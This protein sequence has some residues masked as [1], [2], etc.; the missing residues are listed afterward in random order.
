L[1]RVYVSV[2]KLQIGEVL[3]TLSVCLP[4]ASLAP[5]R[6]LAEAPSW[7]DFVQADPRW[8]PALTR[9]VQGLQVSLAARC[10]PLQTSLGRVMALRAGDFIELGVH[11][12]TVA[13]P[14]GLPLFEGRLKTQSGHQAIQI[15]RVLTVDA[16]GGW[17]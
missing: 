5:I 17:A 13:T 7:G 6:D 15:D 4:L 14:E 9:E 1:D 8:L 12:H 10:Q 11:P 3:G 2:F 16:D